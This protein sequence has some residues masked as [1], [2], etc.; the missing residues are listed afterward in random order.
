MKKRMATIILLCLLLIIALL[1]GCACERTDTEN[2][3]APSNRGRLW[4]Y[5]PPMNR[6]PC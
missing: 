1:A 5:S 6:K 2:M 4:I 3:T